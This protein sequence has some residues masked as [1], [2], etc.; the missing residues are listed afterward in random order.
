MVQQM[1]KDV[2]HEQ[3][4]D[5]EPLWIVHVYLDKGYLGSFH[6][7]NILCKLNLYKNYYQFFLDMKKHL[8]YLLGD[9]GYMREEMFVI[10]RLV[11]CELAIKHDLDAM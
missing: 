1:Q 2:L 4:D 9:L 6:D 7:V 11:K 3:H 8:E 5:P 10:Q